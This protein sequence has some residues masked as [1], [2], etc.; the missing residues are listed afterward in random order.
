MKKIILAFFVLSF[1]MINVFAVTSGCL[2][3]VNTEWAGTVT[4]NDNTTAPL[5]INI[6]QVIKNN[7]SYG[8]I[9][10]ANNIPFTSANAVC[11]TAIDDPNAIF[12]ITIVNSA[13]GITIMNFD[14]AYNP[15]IMRGI[16][17]KVNENALQYGTIKK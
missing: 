6:Q 17:G 14:N 2:G 3:L 13:M 1:S 9:G 11:A 8:L 15:T 4:F 7:V 12:G 10:T 16:Q 5:S